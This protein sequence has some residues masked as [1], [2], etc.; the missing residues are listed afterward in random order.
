MRTKPLPEVPSE[1]LFPEALNDEAGEELES[2]LIP[3]PVTL[4]YESPLE[5]L[6][7]D[8]GEKDRAQAH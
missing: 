6:P 7:G 5:D 2:L 3:R 1:I 4:P 8:W